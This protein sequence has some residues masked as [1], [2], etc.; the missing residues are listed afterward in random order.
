M[1]AQ[2]KP[3]ILVLA[4]II[5]AAIV[6]VVWGTKG[7]EDTKEMKSLPPVTGQPVL[8]DEKAKVTVTEF[9]DY[10]C[11]ACKAW[12]ERILPQLQADYIDSGKVKFSY[13]NV[14]FHGDES[15]LAALAG[16]AVYKQNPEAFWDFHKEVYKRQPESHDDVWINEDLLT[17]I[18]KETVPTLDEAR[19]LADM[20]SKEIT[21]FIGEDEKLVQAYNVQLTPTIAVNGK[22]LED[23]YDY[24]KLTELIEEALQ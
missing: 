23:P 6:V 24:E 3:L 17:Q 15:L 20:K 16:E 5:I 13:V 8:G 14:L 2:R 21:G 9:G 1:K 12:G 19:F 10:K 22:V 18:A 4:T 11:P 7:K